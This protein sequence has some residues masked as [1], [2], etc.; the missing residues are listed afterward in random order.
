MESCVIAWT[1]LRETR[2]WQRTSQIC[3]VRNHCAFL[4][5]QV[6]RGHREADSNRCGVSRVRNVVVENA[7]GIGSEKCWKGG[8]QGMNYHQTGIGLSAIWSKVSDS[9]THRYL[10]IQKYCGANEVDL[11]QI[12]EFIESVEEDASTCEVD[13]LQFFEITGPVVDIQRAPIVQI[14]LHHAIKSK[15]Q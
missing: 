5:E 2:Q 8:E 13:S 4:E 14:M 11:A 3:V 10:A 9:D 12:S 6:C 1:S 7:K 15:C